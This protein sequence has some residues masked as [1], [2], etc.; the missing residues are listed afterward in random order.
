MSYEIIESKGPST[1]PLR[2]SRAPQ[3]GD[4][5]DMQISTL[6]KGQ[7]HKLEEEERRAASWR[8]FLRNLKPRR[9]T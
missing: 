8:A 2:F 4:W 5:D 3:V 6:T 1:Q 9:K 7:R